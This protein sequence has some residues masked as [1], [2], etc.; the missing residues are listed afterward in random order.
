MSRT[1][2]TSAFNAQQRR[3][4]GVYK[5]RARLLVTKL[6]FRQNGVEVLTLAQ[7]IEPRVARERLKRIE[8]SVHDVR[9][10]FH[11]AIEIPGVREA[12]EL[13]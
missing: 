3:S 2:N 6:G 7:R 9:E 11:R 1:W 10:D 8:P 12:N 13:W 4:T 5:R